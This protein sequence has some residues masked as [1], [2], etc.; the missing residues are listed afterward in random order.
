MAR[1]KWPQ[2]STQTSSYRKGSSQTQPF[3]K[4]MIPIIGKKK[5]NYRY[6]CGILLEN[7]N[8]KIAISPLKICIFY[9]EYNEGF[10]LSS[11]QYSLT[12]SIHISSQL[13]ELLKKNGL[14]R[15]HAVSN[16]NIISFINWRRK[17][18]FTACWK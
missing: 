6:L 8:W 7:I 13:L 14:R 17:G 1:K 10:I 18:R 3:F 5:I 11:L 15:V 4:D 9:F 16:K 2:R 12:V